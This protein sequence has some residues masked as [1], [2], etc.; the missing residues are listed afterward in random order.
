[1]KILNHTKSRCDKCQRIIPAQVVEK[2]GRVFLKKTCTKHGTSMFEHVWDDPDIYRGLHK[3]QTSK[4]PAKQVII[5]VTKKCNLN[6]KIC[7]ANANQYSGNELKERDLDMLKDTQ[8]V[9][10]SGGEPTVRE[11]LPELIARV[12]K[13]G[14]RPIIFT[15]GV[16][17][18]NINYLRKLKKAGLGG[19][20]LQLDTLNEKDTEYVRGKTGNESLVGIK[21]QALKNL[22]TL[23]IPV[24]V[25][26]VV[27]KNRNLKD[28]K[29]LHNYI[30][31]F[32]SVTT[33][34]AIPIWLIGRYNIKDFL[35]PSAIIREL[36][37]IYK[38][39]KKDFIQTTEFLCNVDHFFNIIKKNQGRLFGVCM[40]KAL[41]FSWKKQYISISKVFNL[42]RINKKISPVFQKKH[43]TWPIIKFFGY[44]LIWEIIIN[45]IRN[46]YFR[47]A[48]I[49]LITNYI[50]FPRSSF[51]IKNPFRFITVGIFPNDRNIDLDFIKPCNSYALSTDD[52]SLRPACLHYIESEKKNDYR[53]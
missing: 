2:S 39:K 40:L 1:M 17:L 22:E 29:K 49:K 13:N 5:D 46:K 21:K 10:I 38:L 36:C 45:F 35:P 8:Q 19:A 37:K 52:Y 30:L 51:L 3:I 31:Q 34:S 7:F 25:W 12:H 44:F 18:A 53:I 23:K 26:T 16:R 4:G 15:N 47:A 20:L 6:C 42:G 41:V 9:F 27:M 24:S 33:V 50:R 48:F 11:D 32:P 28:L 43:K 14:Q